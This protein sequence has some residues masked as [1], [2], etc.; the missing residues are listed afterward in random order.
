MLQLRSVLLLVL[1]SCGE[2]L[3]VGPD[4][5]DDD[6]GID[7][8]PMMNCDDGNACTVDSCQSNACVHDVMH[9]QQMFTPTGT[10]QMFAPNSCVRNITIDAYGAQ[11]GG[12]TMTNQGGGLGAHIKGDLAVAEGVLLLVLVGA[13]GGT[14]LRVGGGG[15]GT[16]V[17]DAASSAKPYVAAGGGGGAGLN[18]PGLPGLT[19]ENGGNGGAATGGGGT[20]G[21]G[22]VTPSPLTNWA[23]GGGG[24]VSDGASGGGPLSEPCGL[25]VGGKMPRNG[26]AGGAPG[27]A[28]LTATGGFGG[29]GGGQGQCNVTGGGGGA[30]YSGGGGG[31]DNGAP[32][33][34]PGGGGGSFNGGT[35]QVNMAGVKAGEGSV[36]ISW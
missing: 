36:T 18:S 26:G 20:N 33:F 21:S 13:P 3:P 12:S 17:W 23:A 31:I 32:N 35:N 6:G 25:A 4:A 1:V 9:G 14:A 27:G 19:T 34:T 8:C 28:V 10:I 7:L 5:G 16:F 15:G 22:G 11:G 29:G 24:W 2:V 30:G